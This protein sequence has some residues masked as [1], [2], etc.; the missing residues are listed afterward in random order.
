MGKAG[1]ATRDAVR[2]LLNH[3]WSESALGR[4]PISE[5]NQIIVSGTVPLS[6]IS[7]LKQISIDQNDRFIKN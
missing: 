1:I 6:Q 5:R 3:A 4:D 7:N 2:T